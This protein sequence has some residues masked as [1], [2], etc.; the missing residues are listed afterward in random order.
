MTSQTKE[1]GDISNSLGI[2][3]TCYQQI[4]ITNNLPTC[5]SSG[6]R[7]NQQ[8]ESRNQLQTSHLGS[9]I[10]TKTINSL[11]RSIQMFVLY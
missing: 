5:L 9:L 7:T 1:E 6:S 4:T 2:S 8:F 11:S 10:Q 3:D